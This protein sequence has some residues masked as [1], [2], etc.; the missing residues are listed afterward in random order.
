M[1][2]RE[3][4]AER[5]LLGRL[6][7]LA[8][9]CE[10]RPPQPPQ[11]IG[12]APL[13]FDAARAQLAA[14]ELVGPLEPGEDRLDRVRLERV[15]SGRLSGRERSPRAGEATEQ[16]VERVGNGVEIGLRQ[17][18]RRHHAERIAE[19][20]RVLD[21]DQ[22][23]LA[24]HPH[25]QGAPLC[26]E[27]GGVRCID[28][29]VA[30]V[31]ATP[32]QVVELVGRARIAGELGFHLG[33]RVRVEQVAQLLLPEQLAQEVAV[34][35]ERLRPPLGGGRVVLVHVRGDVGE[36]KRRGER[37]GRRRLHLDE[38]ELTG[39]DAVEDALQRRQVEDVL[40]ALAV[41]LEHDRERAVVARDLEQALGLQP[42]LP[43]RRALARAATRD[44]E[45]AGGVLPEAGSEQGGAPH[46]LDD[47]LLDLVRRQEQV[48][49]RRQ[50][51]GLGQVE[52]DPVVR[53]D[54][55]HLEPERVAQA[56]AERHRPRRMH[57]RAERGQDAEAP[58]ADLVAEALDHDR[59]V[60]RDDATVRRGLVAQVGEEVLGR[61]RVEVVVAA[62]PLERLRVGERHDLARGPAD[63]L[64]QL[65]RPADALA[66]P[67]RNGTRA[68]PERARRARGRA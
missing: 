61:Q 43:Q 14:D 25:A 49:D 45:R 20:P 21:R 44:Q 6:D 57:A 13:A 32:E 9:R 65:E 16:H 36:E 17:A 8:Q 54:R 46:L 3:E 35:G 10:R 11:D 31:A 50:H 42:L 48:G 63:L 59:A 51:V 56:G 47:E 28:L 68:H 7:L 62:E 26:L 1:P 67:E 30:E 23:L 55:L 53:P 29:V 15:A 64:P 4:P 27:H 52:R 24:G 33:Q 5:R 38:V 66:L 39:L 60:G 18:A 2:G 58:V 41:G 34:E 37:R 22:P 40:Q 19:Q 12:V